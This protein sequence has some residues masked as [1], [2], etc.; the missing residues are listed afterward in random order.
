[1]KIFISNKFLKTL[2]VLLHLKLNSLFPFFMPISPFVRASSPLSHVRIELLC[3]TT[4]SNKYSLRNVVIKIFIFVSHFF[5]GLIFSL[6]LDE[7]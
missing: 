1:M 6:S 3:K 4:P 7:T 5:L 2:V